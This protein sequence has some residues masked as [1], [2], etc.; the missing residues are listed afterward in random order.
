[1]MDMKQRYLKAYKMTGILATLGRKLQYVGCGIGLTL[2]VLTIYTREVG[3]V[4]FGVGVAV[5]SWFG[6]I[7]IRALSQLMLCVLD[8]A[9]NTSPLLSFEGKS[10]ILEEGGALADD[11]PPAPPDTPPASSIPS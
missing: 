5:A 9:V 1:M 10:Q 3:G 4:A 11:V 6:G 2:V 8:I 7:A